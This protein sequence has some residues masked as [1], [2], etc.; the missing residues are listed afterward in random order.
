NVRQVDMSVT[1][2]NEQRR[3]VWMT[4]ES[5]EDF[6]HPDDPLLTVEGHPAPLRV[7]IVAEKPYGKQRGGVRLPFAANMRPIMMASRLE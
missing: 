2:T 6:L 7:V 1:S 4:S 5:L 3:T